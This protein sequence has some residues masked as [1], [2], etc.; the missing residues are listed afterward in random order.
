MEATYGSWRSPISS[1]LIVAKSISFT[2]VQT[3]GDD[4]Y[5]IEQRPYESGRFV[6]VH[7]T[8]TGKREEKLATPW[9]SHNRVHEYGG[10]S[11]VVHHGVIYFTNFQDQRIYAVKRKGSPTAITPDDGS[12]YAELVFDSVRNRLLAVRELHQEGLEPVNQLVSI[13]LKQGEVQVI[14]DGHDFYAS[15][16]LSADGSKI[17]WITWDHPHMPWD[18][19]QLWLAT[20]NQDGRISQKRCIAG[21]ENESV[22]QPEW[23][24][25]HELYFISDRSGWWNLYR[26][27]E[28]KIVP[29]CPM[30]AEFA[31]PAFQ[32]GL[33]SYQLLTDQ[34]LVCTYNRHGRWGIGLL[35]L[36]T[37]QWKTID[38]PYTYISHLQL[39]TT[40]I[41]CIAGSPT[42]P[43]SI[44]KIDLETESVEVLHTSTAQS[45][46]IDDLSLPQ[47]ITFPTTNQM[48][49]HGFYY[50][51]HHREYKGI[52]S[53]Y[54][55]LIVNCHGG[56][57]AAATT[58]FNLDIQYW[59]SRGF[60]YLDLNY[61][62][63]TGYGRAFQQALY[64]NWG[65]YDV[66]D[67]INGAKYLIQ[68]GAVDSKQTIIR[69]RS[70]G[71]YT[72]LAALSF[73]NFFQAGA[74]YFGVSD[75][76]RLHLETHKFESRYLEKLIGSYPEH[77]QL[78]HQ[79]SPI[80]AEEH[81]TPTIFFQ[82]ELDRIV[83]PNQAEQM[84]D[85]LR[86][87]HCPVACVVFPGEGHGFVKAE[88]LKQAMEG[89][90][91]FY[92][93]IFQFQPAEPLMP[94]EIH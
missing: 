78:F 2:E 81:F 84:A 59:T 21:G 22:R 23:S 15:P 39:T 79:R 77:R 1:D 6:I 4:I 62:G 49:A 72:T 35:Q 28:G 33:P 51:P 46:S 83:P 94:V 85:K 37:G 7:H 92:S 3:D 9:N 55:P 20:C 42:I 27:N 38:T 57:T 30:E 58:L 80:Y 82:G 76:E 24:V 40:E 75:L 10:G 31:G 26:L 90:L 67:S 73:H 36:E 17:A 74:S 43:S 54:P 25:N 93:K 50:P 65:I 44:V 69:G 19:S 13:D 89:E 64:G 53:E 45:F 16:S 71:G 12:R 68:Q 87:R 88:H 32:L 47:E 48:V 18:S 91:Y 86:K 52:D 5:W 14:D 8:S 70:A 34:S 63:S 61:R 29:L 41:V 66:A 56:P 60:A 11:Y